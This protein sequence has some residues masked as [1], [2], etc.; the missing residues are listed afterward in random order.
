MRT[1]LAT[2]LS[3]KTWV[4]CRAYSSAPQKF[5]TQRCEPKV[6]DFRLIACDSALLVPCQNSC[7]RLM[8]YTIPLGNGSAEGD[9]TKGRE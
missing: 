4:D 1:F 8:T 2:V 9:L 6:K 3:E 5:N 7:A